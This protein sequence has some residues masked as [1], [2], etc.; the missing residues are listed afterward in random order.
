[1]SLQLL[2]FAFVLAQPL[3]LSFLDQSFK[4]SLLHQF[5]MDCLEPWTV[6]SH[7]CSLSG[8]T[9]ISH[10]FSF[11]FLAPTRHFPRSNSFT[12]CNMIQIVPKFSLHL[13]L[14]NIY[15]LKI[16]CAPEMTIWFMAAVA[17]RG[18]CSRWWSPCFM[19]GIRVNTTSVISVIAYKGL[20]K[21]FVSVRLN[22]LF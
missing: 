22:I 21:T 2:Y 9:T 16:N 11:M 15:V 12:H 14:H 17:T 10:Y 5:S 3:F 18:H 13:L 4:M 8:C 7:I 19:W 6:V 20:C 1:M